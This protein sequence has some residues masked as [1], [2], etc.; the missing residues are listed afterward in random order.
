M[1][2]VHSR[3]TISPTSTKLAWMMDLR[4]LTT[5]HAFFKFCNNQTCVDDASGNTNM[6]NVGTGAIEFKAK[7]KSCTEQVSTLVINGKKEKIKGYNVVLDDTILFPEG[8]GQINGIDVLRITRRGAEAV[9]FVT[10]EIPAGGEV[11]LKVDWKR[12]FDHMQQHTGQHLIT[13]IAE[14]MYGCPTTSWNLGEKTTSI[15]LD[16]QNLTSDQIAAL[17]TEVNKCIYQRIPVT[18]IVYQDKEDPELKQFR[19][20]GLPDDHEGPVRVLNIEGID[21]TLCC[22]THLSNLAH[23]QMIK[24]LWVEKSKKKDRVNLVYVAGNRILKYLG[25]CVAV[26]KSLT[27][28]LKGPLDDHVEL[29]DKAVKASKTAQKSVQNLL[30]DLAVLE[31]QKFKTDRKPGDILVLHRKEGDNEF[32]N[33]IVREIND[34]TVI[35]FLTVGDDKGQ[36]LFLLSG[37]ADFLQ[38]MGE[39]V[40]ETLEGRGSASRG[41]YQ[42]KANKMSQ[43]SKAEKLIREFLLNQ[44]GDS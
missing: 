18:P 26:E 30:R 8:G 4:M 39:K 31:A 10:S 21:A 15:E 6:C 7:V 5:M 24:L 44:C 32:M 12:R 23:L 3:L 13:A 9:N 14:K 28:V 2:Q 41:P 38:A 11:D 43:R 19:C 25:Q 35:C 34:L 27:S 20:R 29:A 1:G 36:G 17:E 16:I 22:G 40:A 33:I 37:P 42:G